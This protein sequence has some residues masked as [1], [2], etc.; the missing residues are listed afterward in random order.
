MKKY[1]AYYRVS[2]DKQGV[3]GLGLV[4]AKY[5]VPTKT[6][7]Y[8]VTQP[9]LD[10]NYTVILTANVGGKRAETRWSFIFDPKATPAPKVR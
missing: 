4:P 5:D 6:V 8:Q 2:T 9:L 7:S 3:S 1:V 10:K